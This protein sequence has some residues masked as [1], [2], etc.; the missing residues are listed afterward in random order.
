M[1]SVEVAQRAHAMLGEAAFGDLERACRMLEEIGTRVDFAMMYGVCSGLCEGTRIVIDHVYGSGQD[2]MAVLRM[3]PGA[4]REDPETTFAMRFMT[5]WLN[6]DRD[7]CRALF[8]ATAHNP[9]PI[10]HAI[11]VFRLLELCGVIIAEA[12]AV[13]SLRGES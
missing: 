10:G 9:H 2:Q 13:K 4:E 11:S 6:G 7:M 12:Q 8:Q 1:D 5:A 3:A